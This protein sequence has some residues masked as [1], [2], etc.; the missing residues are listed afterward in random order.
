M[1]KR[2]KTPGGSNLGG[3]GV[4]QQIQQLQEQ[5]L[6]AQ[7][8]LKN[9]VVSGSAGGGAVIVEVT[10]DQRILSV[11]VDAGLIEDADQE[12]LQDLI[13]AAVN[14]GLEESRK[15]AEKKL[16]PLAGQGLPF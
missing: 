10:G 8:E 14:Q 6:K 4:M 12:L 3:R 16:G 11:K 2:S 1:S 9:E 5:M 13:L 15:L 7:E